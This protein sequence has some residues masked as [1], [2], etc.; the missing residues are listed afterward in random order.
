MREIALRRIL[1]SQL[2][3]YSYIDDMAARAP[4]GDGISS[5]IV[6]VVKQVLDGS[7][8]ASAESLVEVCTCVTSCDDQH[9]EVKLAQ[10]AADCNSS[11]AMFVRCQV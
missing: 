9:L 5:E 10:K 8:S 3:L 1:Q 11:Q 4:Q 7:V 6:R 2:I